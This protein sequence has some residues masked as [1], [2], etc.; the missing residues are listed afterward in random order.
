[1]KRIMISDG[2]SDTLFCYRNFFS[3]E[4]SKMIDFVASPIM[5]IKMIEKNEYIYVISD[6]YFQ[7]DKRGGAGI[8]ET[9]KKRGVKNRIILTALS[10]YIDPEQLFATRLVRKPIYT[11]KFRNLLPD[12][13]SGSNIKYER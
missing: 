11:K 2:N 8:F 6:I 3:E 5:A 13:I 1:M 12:L 10:N 4:E 7:C 9:A